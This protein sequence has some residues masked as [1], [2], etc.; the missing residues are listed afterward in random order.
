M[1]WP[2][3]PTRA[4]S[5]MISTSKLM[6]YQMLS[7]I[8]WIQRRRHTHMSGSAV[9]A[10]LTVSRVALITCSRRAQ[11][12]SRSATFAL[13]FSAAMPWEIAVGR[14][15]TFFRMCRPVIEGRSFMSCVTV[16]WAHLVQLAQ[17]FLRMPRPVVVA[18]PSVRWKS[19][20]STRTRSWARMLLPAS[21][22]CTSPSKATGSKW[23]AASSTAPRKSSFLPSS[24]SQT[25]K[26]SGSPGV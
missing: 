3:T 16:M 12:M 4:D 23:T 20:V 8:L 2:A 10:S 22:R 19:D 24:S 6:S 14:F 9:M 1:L 13:R 7:T 18:T 21:L 26:K 11:T 17:S 15:R 25:S 5:T